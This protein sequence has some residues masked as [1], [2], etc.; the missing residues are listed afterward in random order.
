MEN[1]SKEQATLAYSVYRSN[2]EN[3]AKL[4][5]ILYG[6]LETCLVNDIFQEYVSL[7]DFQPIAEAEYLSVMTYPLPDEKYGFADRTKFCKALLSNIVFDFKSGRAKTQAIEAYGKDKVERLIND[8]GLVSRSDT[9]KVTLVKGQKKLDR[10]LYAH[11]AYSLYEQYLISTESK[12]QVDFERFLA[13]VASSGKYEHIK[14]Y[15]ENFEDLLNLDFPLNNAPALRTPKRHW[16]MCKPV[17][18]LVAAY[19]DHYLT[20]KNPNWVINAVK[21]SQHKL[22]CEIFDWRLSENGATR[23]DKTKYR[24][25]QAIFVDLSSSP[26]LEREL[27]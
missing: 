13:G 27:I 6:L 11:H 15:A 4:D 1:L 3:K 12:K 24:P 20:A 26:F 21:Q 10:I 9:V 5:T 7:S 2:P 14:L 18:H 23:H 19:Y 22:A 8:Y 17:L 25:I 16:A